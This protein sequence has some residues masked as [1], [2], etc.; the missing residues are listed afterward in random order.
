MFQTAWQLSFSQMKERL[1]D[2]HE[3]VNPANEQTNEQESIN[4]ISIDWLR[5]T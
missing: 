3:M 2:D 1:L 4:S 5:R